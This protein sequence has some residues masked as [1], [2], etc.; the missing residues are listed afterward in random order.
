M[1]IAMWIIGGVCAV[2]LV[3]AVIVT[4]IRWHYVLNIADKFDDDG[5]DDYS[6][7]ITEYRGRSEK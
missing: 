5:H 2:G 3:L 1:Y 7:Y 6:D 4:A